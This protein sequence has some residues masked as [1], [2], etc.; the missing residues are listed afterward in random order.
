[1]SVLA[2]QREVN[3]RVEGSMSGQIAIGEHILQIGSVH[4]GIVNILAPGERP[5]PRPRPTPIDARP[6][7]FRDLLGREREVGIAVSV[8]RSAQ[9]V[10]IYG[11]A[12][13]G[14]TSLLRHLAH[15][16]VAEEFIDG[17][18]YARAARKTADDT[19][20]EIFQAFFECDVPFKP[21][22]VQFRL[23]VGDKNAL[24]LLDDVDWGR[25]E[26]ARLLDAAPGC[27]FV[28]GSPRRQ[29]W[30]EG[31]PIALRGLPTEAALALV[32]RRLGRPFTPEELPLARSLCGA[33]EGHPLRLVQAIG[34]VQDGSKTLGE[35]VAPL[36][37]ESPTRTLAKR[38]MAECSPAERRVL[39][40][41]GA[42]EGLA[43]H[44]PHLAALAK[45]H[46]AEEVLSALRTR[47]LVLAEGS[48]CRLAGTL[49]KHLPKR[50]DLKL[51]SKQALVFYVQWAE[52]HQARGDHER[53]AEEA[54]VLL[55][56]QD[57]AAGAGRWREVLRLGRAMEDALAVRGRWGTWKQVLESELQAAAALGDRAAEARAQHQLGTRD[58]CLG[59]QDSARGHLTS[60]L[61]TREALGDTAG[62]RITR[63]NLNLLPRSVLLHRNAGSARATRLIVRG[64]TSIVC[65]MVIMAGG[66]M[67]R[68]A[69]TAASLRSI[70]L[71]RSQV[72]GGDSTQGVVTLDGPVFSG[73]EVTLSSDRPDFVALPKSIRTGAGE[74][75]GEFPVET[76]RVLAPMKVIIRAAR[77]GIE[78]TAALELVAARD[79]EPP[80]VIGP[81]PEPAGRPAGP[82]GG[83]PEAPN[84]PVD[85]PRAPQP[86]RG[87][88]QAPNPQNPRANPPP[89]APGNA[90]GNPP[91][92][93]P[94]NAGG[95]PPPP[96]PGNA[97]GNPPPP[98]PGIPATTDPPP[99]EPGIPATTD[100]PP[101][102]P[103]IP[104]T[105]DPPPP[106]TVTVVG[107][108]TPP[109]PPFPVFEPPPPVPPVVTPVTGVTLV[110]PVIPTA[111]PPPYQK[112]GPKPPP[113]P[114][115]SRPPP[116]K[117]PPGAPGGPGYP[118]SSGSPSTG[119]GGGG[120]N[121]GK[122][123]TNGRPPANGGGGGDPV[124][125]G[126]PLKS[127]GTTGG[128]D[129]VDHRTYGKPP[130][131]AVTG[132]PGSGTG[133]NRGIPSVGSGTPG[134]GHTA[135]IPNPDLT[136]PVARTSSTAPAYPGTGTVPNSNAGR[137]SFGPMPPA[138]QSLAGRYTQAPVVPRAPVNGGVAPQVPP[139]GQGVFSQP[140]TGAQ[141]GT[142]R[143]PAAV[144]GGYA[145]PGQ[146]GAGGYGQ[147]PAVGPGVRG[148]YGQ[149]IPGARNG[150]SLPS[151]G[152]FGGSGRQGGPAPVP[153]GSYGGPGG[154]Q[155]GG[156]GRPGGMQGG[157][158][159]RPGGMQGGGFGRPG[160]MQGGGPM[161][162]GGR[163]MG[164]SGGFGGHA[165]GGRR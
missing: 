29:V 127:T 89:P 123:G 15:H 22:D 48:R 68:D 42:M 156:F 53:I 4:G 24:I 136:K 9:P 13:L 161:S 119:Q 138:G 135:A 117:Y 14:K 90:G 113:P 80:P 98:E 106:T 54:D 100:P 91:P 129:P 118:G 41:L 110:I 59:Q 150:R 101:P 37:S 160:G 105:T 8:L 107:T 66:R 26:V 116:V 122:P 57:W 72:V 7:A 121:P 143:P 27:T 67:G 3:I 17:I 39:A 61:H 99:P 69:F 49:V 131:T 134:V 142:A 104:A 92:P 62:A 93:A 108:S 165:G 88:D 109:G 63:H 56:L 23:H 144:Q 148:G 159:G 102:E 6:R 158:F 103:G 21:T 130:G 76:K 36:R 139:A 111:P 82:Q 120:T 16:H 83:R 155:G 163:G 28:L 12:G 25:E 2:T 87:H 34:L 47:G 73:A 35:I 149:T 74:R 32:E 33:L 95:N 97:G 51:C 75:A 18:V 44:A 65:L 50:W 128:P 141:P 114:P 10:E 19:F 157:G 137:P 85:Q 60:A 112:P 84:N 11:R 164:M 145:S 147:M 46:D 94:R 146:N 115:P 58:L 30:E 43:V 20:Q 5:V 78:R 132:N 125:S 126:T 133:V 55:F 151:G 154:M 52:R 64:I 1:M 71:R 31:R 124:T 96:A 140:H 152:G 77:D 153:G 40:M 38:A 45:L 86:D 79:P 81:R 162:S 70:E